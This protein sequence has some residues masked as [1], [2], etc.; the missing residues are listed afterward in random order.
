MAYSPSTDTPTVAFGFYTSTEGIAPAP[1][2]IENYNNTCYGLEAFTGPCVRVN[3]TN[4]FAYNNLF[5]TVGGTNVATANCA[6]SCTG[7]T[8]GNNTGNSTVTFNPTNGSGTFRVITDFMP[9]QNYTGG[10]GVPVWYDAH[11]V[12]WSPT[13]NFGAL[14]P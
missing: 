1:T 4:S 11:E 5:Y 9:T 12:A 10:T 6:S 2:A 13:W 8:T 7:T 14:K 3:A